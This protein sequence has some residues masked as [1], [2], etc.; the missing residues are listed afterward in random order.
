[1]NR[2]GWCESCALCKAMAD[3][4]LSSEAPNRGLQLMK[5]QVHV[6]MVQGRPLLQRCLHSALYMS[7]GRVCAFGGHVC[8][9][10]S[11]ACCCASAALLVLLWSFYRRLLSCCVRLQLCAEENSFAANRRAADSKYAQVLHLDVRD[12][13]FCRHLIWLGLS[14]CSCRCAEPVTQRLPVHCVADCDSN[15]NTDRRCI[16]F[17]TQPASRKRTLYEG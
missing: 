11:P 8:S 9:H 3:Q 2:R 7:C 5:I 17:Q 6:D 15:L 4:S 10:C 12:D 1:M 14:L 16:D 13:L